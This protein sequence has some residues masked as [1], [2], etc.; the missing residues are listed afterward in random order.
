MAI[1]FGIST[2]RGREFSEPIFLHL[3]RQNFLV[4][5]WFQPIWKICSSKLDHVPKDRVW[6][7]KNSVWN[8]QRGDSPLFFFSIF[9]HVFLHPPRVESSRRLHFFILGPAQ[10]MEVWVV[11][12][13]MVDGFPIGMFS[14]QK[15]G[16]GMKISAVPIAVE[17]FG[18]MIYTTPCLKKSRRV[19]ARKGDFFSG[20]GDG[21]PRDIYFSLPWFFSRY[22]FGGVKARPNEDTG[23]RRWMEEDGHL[24]DV[25]EVVPLIYP[26]H[27]W[28]QRCYTRRPGPSPAI[29]ASSSLLHC[30]RWQNSCAKCKRCGGHHPVLLFHV[31]QN[32]YDP[33]W[34]STIYTDWFN[35][36][37]L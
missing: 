9:L 10:V 37:S 11:V 23:G 15:R 8:H 20:I 35:M 31:I 7:I 32:P 27:P 19:F 24:G 1:G 33:L 25:S 14:L 17:F 16:G 13:V 29:P 3:E 28:C 5:G 22:F 4:G 12:D 18:E 21:S 26:S 30:E 34:P 2:L 6:N 36:G